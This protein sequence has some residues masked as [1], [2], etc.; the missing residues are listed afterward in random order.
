[1]TESSRPT[2]GSDGS[3]LQNTAGNDQDNSAETS[4]SPQGTSATASS[5][6]RSP[7]RKRR[8]VTHAC[9]YCRRSH[10]TCDDERPCTR[11]VKR[12]IGHLCHDEHRDP[13]K[14][15]TE[16]TGMEDGSQ[17]GG[18]SSPTKSG[19]ASPL[20][21]GSLKDKQEVRTMGSLAPPPLPASTRTSGQSAPPLSTQTV[22]TA[23]PRNTSQNFLGLANWD[24]P[25]QHHTWNP[26]HQQWMFS[27]PDVSS[28]FNLLSDF[29]GNFHDDPHFLGDGSSLFGDGSLSQLMGDATNALFADPRLGPRTMDPLQRPGS[30]RPSEKSKENYYL[31]AAD[32]SK[33]IPEERMKQVLEAKQRAGMLQPFNYVKGYTRLHQFMEK[34]MQPRSR[35]RITAQLDRFRPKFREKTQKLTDLDLV[36]VEEWFEKVLLEYDRIFASMAVPACLWRRTGQIY[37]GN[38]EFAEL[39]NV[40]IERMRDGSLTI[41]ELVAE[42]SAKAMLTSCNLKNPDPKATNKL[43]NCCFSFTIRRDVYDM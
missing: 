38:K 31:I 28:E 18:L 21:N 11:C 26:Y 5:V 14:A 19:Q 24:V 30:T 8:K 23:A 7:S 27:A 32:P 17:Q 6:G 2:S 4:T 1:M 42:D 39:I 25:Q 15:K 43:I 41:Y 16:E 3:A 37:R 13:K 40:P 34:N 10:M 33:D 35:A 9:V 12:H 36:H 20:N 22:V 29:A